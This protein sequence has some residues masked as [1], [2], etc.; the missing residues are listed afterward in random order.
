[1]DQNI[2]KNILLNFE[3]RVTAVHH[4][5]GLLQRHEGTRQTPFTSL[6]NVVNSDFVFKVKYILF[7]V[8]YD[9]FWDTLI[10]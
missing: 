7:K 1:M 3:K 5:L 10:L 4:P 8:K 6:A 2:Q 9:T